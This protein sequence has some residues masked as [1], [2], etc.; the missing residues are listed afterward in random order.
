MRLG[1]LV[2]RRHTMRVQFCGSNHMPGTMM[3]MA[4]TEDTPLTT[5]MLTWNTFMVRTVRVRPTTP[6]TPRT[7]TKASNGMVAANLVARLAT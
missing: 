5:T 1:A 6:M 7:A 4:A 2:L 3:R